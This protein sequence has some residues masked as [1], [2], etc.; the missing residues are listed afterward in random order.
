MKKKPIKLVNPLNQEQWLCDDFSNV[1]M[2]EDVEY[3]TVY[4]PDSP[5][6][7]HLMRKEA[8]RKLSNT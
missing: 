4:K 7:T 3:V 5:N 8:L 6:R 2:V 1:R